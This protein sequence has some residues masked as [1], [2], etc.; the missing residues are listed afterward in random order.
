MNAEIIS[1]GD[2]IL[3]GQVINTNASWIAENL[4]YLGFKI[5]RIISVSDDQNEILSALEDSGKKADLI[6][7]TGGLGPT[8]DDITKSTL[9]EYFNSELI[10][11]K[12]V[13]KDIK[14]LFKHRGWG[15]E[16]SEVNRKQAEVPSTAVAI[17][18]KCGTAPGLWF[19]KGKKVYIITPGV[20][21]EMKMMSEKFILPRLQKHFKTES[22]YYK[23]ILTQGIGE[24]SLA[25]IIEE[26]ENKLPKN[27][28]LAYL[29]QPGIVRLRITAAGKDRKLLVQIINKQIA[30]LKE[31]IPD[32][33]Y[34]YDNDL[35]EGICGKLLRS[36]NLTLST[37]ESC[38]GGYIAHLITSI[39]GS[40]DYFKGSVIAYSNEIKQKELKVK[41]SSLIKFGAVSEQVVKEMADGIRKKFRT[42]FAVA[43]SGIAGPGGATNDKQV[44]TTWIAIAT[45]EKIIAQK[46]LF[47]EDRERNIRKAGITALNML[48]KE[49]LIVK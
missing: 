26:W 21:F 18:N 4:T 2:E 31:I 36:K 9:C 38:T 8:N 14:A 23:T 30:T 5:N 41:E 43:T 48:R 44:G 27:I 15:T 29:P 16:I 47:G 34:G 35:L 39:P 25:E 11:D 10:I 24:S 28:K 42:D 46:F 13:L 37:A 32:F 6:F 45:P 3:I 19:E 20:P 40:S 12:K 22:I 17:P 33:I 1:I 49:I 7:I